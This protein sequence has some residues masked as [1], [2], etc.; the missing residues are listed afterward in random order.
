[1]S[2]YEVHP[3]AAGPGWHAWRAD[4]RPDFGEWPQRIAASWEKVTH[5]AIETGQELLAAKTELPPGTFHDMIKTTLPF[6]PRMAQYLMSIAEHPVL[7]DA[8][9]VSHLPGDILTLYQL[10]R[11]EAPL[12]EAKI[13]EG[14]INPRL[15]RADVRRKVLGIEEPRRGPGTTITSV[16]KL[17]QERD[18][19]KSTVVDQQHH[20]AELEAARDN[21]AWEAASPAALDVK[22]AIQCLADYSRET[23]PADV[24][25]PLDID[26]QEILRVAQWLIDLVPQEARGQDQLKKKDAT[27]RFLT[28]RSR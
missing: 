20:I 5:S 16:Q 2:Q 8:K 15:R 1:M 7:T 12:V 23:K 28:R 6:G 11:L 9:H 14:T 4:N 24:P 13:A 25:Q 3:T 27:A 17:R 18:A 21:S 26:R 22:A 10:S 19:L